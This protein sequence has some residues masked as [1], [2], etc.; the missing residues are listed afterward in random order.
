MYYNG[1]QVLP[2][3]FF[4]GIVTALIDTVTYQPYNFRYYLFP[5]PPSGDSLKAYI[6]NLPTGT[7][8][9]LAVSDD[10]AQSVLG[11]SSGTPVRNSIKT[12][13]S[14][15]IDSV[16]Y[17]ESWCI[18]GKKGAQPGTVP[19]AYRK[20]FEGIAELEFNK[21]ILS[22]SGK[23]VF[24]VISNSTFWNKLKRN[25]LQPDGS[26]IQFKP[27]GIKENGVVDTLNN[28]VFVGDS[29]SISYINPNLYSAIKLQANLSRNNLFQSPSIK[30]LGV[31]YKGLPEIAINYQT[32]SINKDSVDYN[33]SVKLSFNVMNL[34]ESKADSLR[35]KIKVS[36]TDY[37]ERTLFDT[38]IFS[39]DALEKFSHFYVY[40]NDTTDGTGLLNFKII[41]DPDNQIKEF[42]ELN[43]LYSIPF[44]A[45]PDTVTTSILKANLT[46]VLFDDNIVY[47]GDYTSKNPKVMI[48]IKYGSRFPFD[49]STA[50]RFY[51]NNILIPYSSLLI[52]ND[53]ATRTMSI[54]FKPT[55]SD[56]EH[57]FKIIGED[58]INKVN[59]DEK[60]ELLFYV[61]SEI[62]IIDLYNYPNPFSDET[63]FTF[64]LPEIPDELRIKIYT[65]AGR[66]IKE[67]I[68]NSEQLKN[69]FNV[70]HWD[71]KDADGNEVANGVYIYKAII[72]KG[73]KVFST[74]QKLSILK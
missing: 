74:N 56:G 27:L 16:M 60:Y 47:S 67:L 55:L 46:K 54:H 9:A 49:D 72:R 10:A 70:I 19:E 21:S 28:V 3:S 43:N 6:D 65:I 25:I 24:P 57:Q 15:Y 17:R 37:T 29:A 51:L 50:I 62:A 23:I 33:D 2:N 7:V 39:L 26:N 20:R 4:W 58:L 66:F 44:Y 40:K 35:I 22:D 41:A 12:L 1:Q 42:S 5:T 13:G 38:L 8:I 64:R 32:V 59:N 11:F 68:V 69:S 52:I 61:S 45:R 48:E 53:S 63:Y 71:G 73:E 14:I 30:S 18:I 34:G 36:R 31:K